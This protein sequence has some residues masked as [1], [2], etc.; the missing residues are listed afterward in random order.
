ME[1]SPESPT[2]ESDHASTCRDLVAPDMRIERQNIRRPSKAVTSEKKIA[3]NRRNASKSSGPR[4][5]R[6]KGHS[7]FNALKYG[8]YAES[9]VLPGES[10]EEHRARLL[11]LENELKPQGPIQEMYLALI[12][13]AMSQLK[14]VDVACHAFI[15]VQALELARKMGDRDSKGLR[16]LA[17]GSVLAGIINQPF[18]GIDEKA[19]RRRK[20]II[21]EMQEYMEALRESKRDSAIEAETQM[22]ERRIQAVRDQRLLTVPTKDD[23]DFDADNE[24]DDGLQYTEA[25]EKYCSTGLIQ[26][27]EGRKPKCKNEAKK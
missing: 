10:S 9:Q 13:G 5:K 2:T 16:T 11:A 25:A 7:S 6:G 1:K 17:L 27:A 14:R 24:P 26:E 4:T 22:S 15:S 21:G 12:E 18:D 8:L 23:T 20:Q 3:S 19:A